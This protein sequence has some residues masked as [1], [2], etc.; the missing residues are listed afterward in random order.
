MTCFLDTSAVVKLFVDEDGHEP[1]RA[2]TQ[3]PIVIADIAIVELP[4][5]LYR[6]HRMGELSAHAA[7]LL[8]RAF[9]AALDGQAPGLD[10][11]LVSTEVP[12]L[13]ACADLVRRHPL[14]AY[15][16]VQLGTALAASSVLGGCSFGSFD[17]RL[18]EAAVAE[19][20]PLAW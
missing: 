5:A 20:L 19:G 18:N 7:R 12:L 4:A 6:K 2:L 1:V 14:R 3:A 11:H 13:R 8:D 10:I 17:V 15:D 9:A 16:A